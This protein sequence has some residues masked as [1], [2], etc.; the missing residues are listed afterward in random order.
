MVMIMMV[1][2]IVV[3]MVVVNNDDGENDTGDNVDALCDNQR[4]SSR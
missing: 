2:M 3:I 4:P 1:M